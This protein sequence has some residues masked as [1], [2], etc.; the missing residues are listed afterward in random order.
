M[1]ADC[2]E[3]VTKAEENSPPNIKKRKSNQIC[4]EAEAGRTVQETF[5]L[6]ISIPTIIETRD[7]NNSMLNYTLY[8]MYGMLR[9][10]E[11]RQQ[12]LSYT[13]KN[14]FYWKRKRECVPFL[15]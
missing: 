5:T 1:M 3:A 10:D 4:G 6:S 11:T 13:A 14:W 7:N 12:T 8:G 9:R 2:N 15:L